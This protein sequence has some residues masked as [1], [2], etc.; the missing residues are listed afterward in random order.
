LVSGAKLYKEQPIVFDG[1]RKQ[2][3]LLVEKDDELIVVD[4]KSSLHVNES[5]L[6]QI[7]FYKKALEKISSKKVS[8]YLVYLRENEVLLKKA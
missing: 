6:A 5:H 2:L 8:A 3:D 7:G 1:E 4:Y